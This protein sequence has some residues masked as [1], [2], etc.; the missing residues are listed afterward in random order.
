MPQVQAFSLPELATSCRTGRPEAVK[1]VRLVAAP[2][3]ET[4]KPVRFK[5]DGGAVLGDGGFDQLAGLGVLEPGDVNGEGVQPL[6]IERRDDCLDQR[7]IA[8]LHQ[9]PVEDDGSHGPAVAAGCSVN[10]RLRQW[11]GGRR[12]GAVADQVAHQRQDRRRVVDPAMQEIAMNEVERVGGQGREPG[13]LRVRTVVAREQC[14][15]GAVGSGGKHQL[16]D[17]IGPVAPPAEQA[18][19]DQAR[20]GR[21]LLDVEVDRERVLQLE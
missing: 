18:D 1:G 9:R 11:P 19:G 7:Q 16:L 21:G 2:G 15:R 5:H 17:A 6:G 3:V 20:L 14:E 4:A 8:A 12:A 13:E 10:G